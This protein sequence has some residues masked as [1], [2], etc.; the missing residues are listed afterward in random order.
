MKRLSKSLAHQLYDV[1]S[2]D[3]HPSAFFSVSKQKNDIIHITDCVCQEFDNVFDNLTS[4]C[5]SVTSFQ[6]MR[7]LTPH[8]E[9]LLQVHDTA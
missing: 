1:N 5:D 4:S 7:L 2:V 8:I 3:S 9:S 6:M